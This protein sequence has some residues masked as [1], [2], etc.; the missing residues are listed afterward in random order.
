MAAMKSMAGER[1][2]RLRKLWW[3]ASR[4]LREDQAS[5]RKDE[6]PPEEAAA[7]VASAGMTAAEIEELKKKR[8]KS[9]AAVA[10]SSVLASADTLG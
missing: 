3:G 2:V 9:I 5:D 6:Q 8:G 4:G 1:G 10:P 7:P